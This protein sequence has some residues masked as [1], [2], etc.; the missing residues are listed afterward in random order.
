MD[1]KIEQPYDEMIK[2]QNVSQAIEAI[3]TENLDLFRKSVEG[4]TKDDIDAITNDIDSVGLIHIAS[5]Y[6]N[7]NT[8]DII[9]LLIGKI[10]HSTI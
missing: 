4:L 6:R 7:S 3:K 5:L 1:K 2:H 10:F 9:S 8:K